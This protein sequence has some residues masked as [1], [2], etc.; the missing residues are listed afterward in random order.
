MVGGELSQVVH[1][2]VQHPL[3]SSGVFTAEEELPGVSES[4]HL[5]QHRLGVYVKD[6]RLARVPPEYQFPDSTH[7]Q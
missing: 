3:G 1:G 6:S 2:G 5:A 4:L 7:E